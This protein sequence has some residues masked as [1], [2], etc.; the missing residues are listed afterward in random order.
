MTFNIDSYLLQ[1]HCG[2]LTNNYNDITV[3]ISGFV[4]LREKTTSTFHMLLHDVTY[5]SQ[6]CLHDKLVVLN[7]FTMIILTLIL[8]TI[9]V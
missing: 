5:E 3:I 1:L 7:H 2:F 6:L 9:L 8:S 4:G